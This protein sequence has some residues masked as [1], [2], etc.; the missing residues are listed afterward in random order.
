MSNLNIS[1]AVASN[2]AGWTETSIA[3]KSTDGATGVDETTYQN[4][5]WS[6]QWGYF[7]E[8][9]EL[10]SAIIMRAIWDV[11]KGYEA[12]P[13][14][15]VILDHISGWGKDTFE[16]I[17]FNLDVDKYVGRDSFAHIIWDDKEK[18]NFPMNIKVLDPS[19]IKI[20]VD[21]NGILIRYEQVSKV[22]GKANKEFKP[23]EIFHLSNNRLAD[24]IH[25]IS[26]IESLDKTLLA[27]L[28]SFDNTRKIMNRQAKPFIIFH[29]KTDDIAKV[30]EMKARIDALRNLGEDLHLPDENDVVKWEVVTVNVSE[31]I[32]A[33]RQDITNRF[34]RA[35]GMPLVLFGAQ[36]STES[37]GKME[38]FA[39]ENVW[40][41]GQRS[42]ENQVWQQLHLRINLIPPQSMAQGLATD[43]AK[44]QSA[45]GMPQGLEMG[46]PQDTTPGAGE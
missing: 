17:L 11:G 38:V 26:V 43:T 23:Y 30:N 3:N 8:H 44:D 22:P 45:N 5:E 39:H 28:E 34:Y 32:L 35:L 10:K 42:I 20:I 15:K 24:Q 33:W 40:E 6:K 27:D 25:G 29:W 2:M 12:D 1:N 7:N 37:G 18:R 19:S 14:V 4:N 31:T 36:G 9:P 41:H 13:E 16:E 46:Q 21:E